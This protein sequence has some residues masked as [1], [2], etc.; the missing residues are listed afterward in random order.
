MV[1]ADFTR[2]SR[3]LYEVVT[4]ARSSAVEPVTLL[5]AL[6]SLRVLREEF[7]SWE[8]E[9]IEAAR[10]EGVSWALLAPALGVASRQ[11]AERRF[12]RLRPSDGGERT[13]EA[14]V[15]AERDRR[16]GDRAVAEW[17]RRNS[18]MLR[19]VAGQAGAV[20]GLSAEGRKSADKLNMAL[21]ENDVADLLTPLADMRDHLTADH[22][23]LADRLGAI[24]EHTGQVRQDALDSRRRSAT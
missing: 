3:D 20:E 8:P 7:A 15:D 16:A 18:A 23:H 24:S 13:G 17:A 9:L 10:A 2:R 11:A 1:E 14:R 22:L 5:A 12:L 6:E 21:G 4:A 19:Q